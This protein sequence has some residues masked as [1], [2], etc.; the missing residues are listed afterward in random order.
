MLNSG[1]S[2]RDR[3]A[4]ADDG[5]TVLHYLTERYRH[6][7]ESRWAA[8]IDSGE[9]LLDGSTALPCEPLRAGQELVWNRPPWREPVAPSGFAL[10][11][12]DRDLVGVLKPRGLP[13]M[14]GGGFL[15]RTLLF[16]VRRVFPEASPLHRLG[17]GTSGLVLFSRNPRAAAKLGKAW[18]DGQVER[19]YRGWVEGRFPRGT[20]PIEARI[21]LRPHRRLGAV[22]AVH[23]Q[24]KTAVSRVRL[25]EHRPQG[26]LVEVRIRTGR[27]HQIR[28]HLAAHGHPLVGDPL[29]PRGGVPEPENETLPGEGGYWLHAERLG[30]EHPGSG[31]WLELSS[32]PP[33]VLRSMT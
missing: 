27:T 14:P 12:R 15:E 32:I 25:L 13:T 9:V 5:R 33:P 23:P 26:S 29:Y 6:S 10:V 11:H 22:Y 17:R 19:V 7:S 30:F 16:R 21:G 18:H 3:V 1:Y 31:K 2:Y 4:L 8:R 28:I 24:G 20:V